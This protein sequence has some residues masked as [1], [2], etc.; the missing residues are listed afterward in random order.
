[1]ST[2][3]VYTYHFQ[4]FEGA[5]TKMQISFDAVVR[6]YYSARGWPEGE[7]SSKTLKDW[8]SNFVFLER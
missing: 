3:I 8:A 4:P 2:G 5:A 1:M 6:E 7:T